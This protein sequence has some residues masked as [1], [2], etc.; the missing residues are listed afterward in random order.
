MSHFMIRQ[1][2]FVPLATV[3][4]VIVT[5][6]LIPGYSSVSQ[7]M[8]EI[9]T[10]DRPVARVLHFGAMVAGASVVLFGIGLKVR[11]PKAF[12]FT[13]LAAIT[14]GIAYFASGIFHSGSPL[15][16]L[17]GLTALYVLV[18]AFFAAELPAQMRSPFIVRT[19][20]L[21]ALLSLC[22]MSFMY[23]GV[24]PDAV[25]GITQRLAAL[26]IFGW[27]PVASHWLLRTSARSSESTV[28]DVARAVG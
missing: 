21:A 11:H 1:A 17:Y 26:V 13:A 4:M 10:L 7:H 8:S 18:P 2:Q 24:E 28:A 6:V 3:L 23:A 9:G 20:L 15:H 27:Y 12:N 19:S 25:R 22:Y 14:F 16:G 5:G